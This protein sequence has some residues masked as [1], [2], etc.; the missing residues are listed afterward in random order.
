MK[1]KTKLSPNFDHKKYRKIKYII[2]HYTGMK[3]SHSAIKRLRDKRSKVSCHYFIDDKGL[4]TRLVEDR[5]VAWH[6][7]ISY[8]NEDKSLNKNS[9]GVEIQN[10]G[11]L[12]KYEKYK[13]IQIKTLVTLILNLKNKYKIN[14]YHIIGHS[15]IA[16]SRKTDPGYLFPWSHLNKKGIGLLPSIRL[17]KKGVLKNSQIPAI[18]SLLQKFG[19]KIKVTGNMDLQTILVLNAFQS[20]Y[21]QKRIKYFLYDTSIL[22]ILRDLIE[23]KNRCLTKK[24]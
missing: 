21:L 11:E 17:P 24:N 14:D 13:T 15:D 12:L 10:K 9:I 23:Q 3:T 20:H 7:G 19:Y 18:Q 16:P 1:I 2:I 22:P 4:L 8:W 5:N 6:A